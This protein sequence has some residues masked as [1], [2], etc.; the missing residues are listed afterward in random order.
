M[1]TMR[2]LKQSI[3]N[4]LPRNRGVLRKENKME[5]KIGD[6][7][8]MLLSEDLKKWRAERPDEWTMDRFIR[9]AKIL[10]EL[11]TVYSKQ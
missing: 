6:K 7:Q 11:F 4:K 3:R 8:E 9:K 10:E 2:S 5:V 1:Q